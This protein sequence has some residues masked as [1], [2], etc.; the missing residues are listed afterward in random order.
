[1]AKTTDP[2]SSNT[3]RG[4]VIVGPTAGGKTA[5]GVGCALACA[6]LDP[7][8]GV[9]TGEVIS[10]DAYQIYKEM[11]IG[12]AKPPMEERQGVP[13]HLIDIKD[14]TEAYTLADWLRDANA[15]ID[16]CRARGAMPIVVGGTHLYVKALMDGMFEG[17]EPDPRIRAELQARDLADLRAELER[18]DPA[19]AQRIHSN[20][21]RRTV[22]ALEVFHQ[23]GTTMTQHQSQWDRGARFDLMIVGLD[24]ETEAINRRIN[25]RVKW[26]VE[27]GLVE[28]VRALWEAG[29]L[30]EQAGQALG[31]KQ[32]IP[33]FEGR[34]S[35]TDAVE[36]I[37]IQTR[38]FCKNQRTWLRRLRMTPGS[39]WLRPEDLSRDTIAQ[40]VVERAALNSPIK[41]P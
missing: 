22:R 36:Q 23:T 28:E 25:A 41:S 9:R 35:L 40:E 38:R 24:W 10:A 37:K 33:H 13:H 1:M 31:Y 30:G 20:D 15:L 7:R 26:M 32:L 5:L 3:P 34:Q 14:P 27:Q 8:F 17:P 2:T 19:S 18:V 21:Q 16:E 29:R 39:L 6:G 11:D 12:T 4:L